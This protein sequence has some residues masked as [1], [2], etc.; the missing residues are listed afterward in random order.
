METNND[1]ALMED[2]M[3][4]REYREDLNEFYK[5][6]EARYENNNSYCAK[7]HH[8][9]GLLPQRVPLS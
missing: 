4:E 1:S 9:R 2:I 8:L 6:R 7:V 5:K 3:Q